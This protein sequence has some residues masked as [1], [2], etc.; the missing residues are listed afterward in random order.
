MISFKFSPRS[1]DHLEG[2]LSIFFVIQH[3]LLRTESSQYIIMPKSRYKVAQ[4]NYTCLPGPVFHSVC[5]H[6]GFPCDFNLYHNN[7]EVSID[8]NAITLQSSKGVQTLLNAS[9]IYIYFFFLRNIP[10]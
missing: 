9:M 7:A 3:Q 10:T 5:L 4:L 6:I 8:R 2:Q 1:Q